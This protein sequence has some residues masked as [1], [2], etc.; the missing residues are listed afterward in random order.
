[1]E[2]ER[3]MIPCCLPISGRQAAFVFLAML[4]AANS[5]CLA[6]AGV[7]A[8][9]AAGAGGYAYMKGKVSY[10]FQSSVE[11]TW[12]AARKSLAELQMP[13]LEEE[14]QASSGGFFRSETTDG[15]AVRIYLEAVEEEGPPP[16]RGTE[17]T[18]RVGTFG[19][20]TVS[21]KILRQLSAHLVTIAPGTAGAP[22]AAGGSSW[23][24]VNPGPEQRIQP[25]AV[26]QVR[27]EPPQP[28]DPAQPGNRITPTAVP[29]TTTAP[30]PL[31]P[32]QPAR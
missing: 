30:P 29:P 22:V 2:E 32:P 4:A 14:R 11:D 21:D 13:I 26:P 9:G 19:D 20:Y 15:T 1:M 12:S 7:A 3:P 31:L 27:I 25:Q 6:A 16:T 8:A 23:T 24:A 28:P 17:V 18:V 10:T 5:G